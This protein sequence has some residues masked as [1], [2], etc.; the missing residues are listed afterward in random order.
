MNGT[1]LEIDGLVYWDRRRWI[2]VS[3]LVV[4]SR[5]LAGSAVPYRRSSCETNCL[6]KRGKH[7]QDWIG[8]RP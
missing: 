8:G 2:V 4:E 5:R 1:V 3:G 7:G 6:V